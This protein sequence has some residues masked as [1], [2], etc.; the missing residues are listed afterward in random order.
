MD[1]TERHQASLTKLTFLRL[2]SIGAAAA[3]QDTGKLLST[4]GL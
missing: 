2:T 3:I 1:N 4:W